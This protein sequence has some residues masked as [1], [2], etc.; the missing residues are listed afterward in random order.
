MRCRAGDE[1]GTP[2]NPSS[3]ALLADRLQIGGDLLLTAGFIAEGDG[4]QGEPDEASQ[5]PR[6]PAMRP[7]LLRQPQRILGIRKSSL[8]EKGRSALPSRG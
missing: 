2:R 5:A 1:G 6:C 8:K 7:H 4:A 3:H